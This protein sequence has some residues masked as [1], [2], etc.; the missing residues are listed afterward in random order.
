MAEGVE[1]RGNRVRV[2]FRF[3]GEL[4]REAIAGDATPANI[5]NAERLAGIINYEIK[6]GTFSYARHFPDSPRIKTNT[7][8][9][10]IDLWLDIKRN[11]LAASGFRGYLSRVENHI[12]PRWGNHQADQIDHLDLQSWVQLELMPKLH[13]KT[14]REIVSN[15]RQIFRLYRTRNKTAHDPTDG[16]VITLPDSDDPDPFTRAEIAQILST[17]SDRTQELNM[18]EFMMWTGPRISEAMALA[19]EDV[20][21]E[22]G[23]VIFR[24][25]RVRSQYKVTKTRRSTRKVTLLAPSLRALK[26]QVKH[27][28]NLPPVEIE[29]TDRDNRTKKVQKVRFVFHNTASGEAYS[30]SDTLRNGWWKA[31]LKKAGIRP[32]GPNQCRHTFASQMLTSGIATPE[33]IADQMGHTSTAMIF[34]HYATWISKD[35]PDFVG[36][37]NQALKLS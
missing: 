31:H 3:E 2:Y 30:T 18:V 21:L 5:A 7:L 26:A 36:L 23:T 33:W 10:Y 35:G 34:K 20:D 8:G 27:T 4:C 14:V 29:I 17:E 12:R 22:A 13:N 24:R 37:L 32:R 9:H 11:H 28:K 15:M 19:W 1:V 16:I 25:A 6:N